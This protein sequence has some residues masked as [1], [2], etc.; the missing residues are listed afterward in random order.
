VW[1]W[2]PPGGLV[3]CA[4]VGSHWLMVVARLL[5]LAV[6][7]MIWRLIVSRPG[8]DFGHWFTVAQAAPM[9]GVGYKCLQEMC[10]AK[11][12]ECKPILGASGRVVKYLLSERQIANHNRQQT[13][14]ATN[15]GR[16]R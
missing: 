11:R 4:G 3:V 16:L 10:A 12:I 8:D 9:I 13:Q 2:R 1:W 5:R 14:L 6:V 7:S 15:S